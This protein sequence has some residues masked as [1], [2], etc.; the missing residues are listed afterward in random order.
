M[1]RDKAV[2][3]QSD[4]RSKVKLPWIRSGVF[5]LPYLSG[6]HQNLADNPSELAPAPLAGRLLRLHRAGPSTALDK[7][8]VSTPH[9]GLAEPTCFVN[10]PFGQATKRAHE[11]S[12]SKVL[13]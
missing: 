13:P 11:P 10:R 7:A 2:R 4:S 6:S 12:R 5:T 3:S 1:R 8:A 9:L